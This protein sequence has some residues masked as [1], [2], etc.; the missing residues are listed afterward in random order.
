MNMNLTSAELRRW[1]ARCDMRLKDA[2]ISGEEH[3]RL[4]KLR[5]GLVAVADAQDWLDGIR[6]DGTGMKKA[7]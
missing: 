2:L 1:A 7:G 4:R 6:F 3:E 5:D